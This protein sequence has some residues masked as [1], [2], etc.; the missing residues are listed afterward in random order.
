[1][2]LERCHIRAN[3]PFLAIKYEWGRSSPVKFNGIS[4]T[5]RSITSP[6]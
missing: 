5:D 3:E 6:E 1:M 4:Q 2:D